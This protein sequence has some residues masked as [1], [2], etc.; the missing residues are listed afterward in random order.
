MTFNFNAVPLNKTEA[1]AMTL[2]ALKWFVWR[3]QHG[4]V[5]SRLTVAVFTSIIETI[6][7]LYEVDERDF[8]AAAYDDEVKEWFNSEAAAPGE[9]AI[10]RESYGQ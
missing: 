9:R 4:M 10:G 5:M 1:L 3:Q 6:E 8:D 7:R 2:A